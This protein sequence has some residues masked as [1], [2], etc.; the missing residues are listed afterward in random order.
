MAFE[1][2]LKKLEKIV[3]ELHGEKISLDKAIAKFEEGV[4]LADTCLK[5]LDDMR[6]RVETVTKT[7]DGKLVVRD[8]GLEEPTE[9]DEAA[10]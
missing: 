1:E 8:A 6:R 2:N 7:K 3:D 4:K 9:D 10:A 5:A